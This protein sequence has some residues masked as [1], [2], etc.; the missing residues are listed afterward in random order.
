MRWGGEEVQFILERSKRGSLQKGDS[1]P[2]A[3]QKS[4]VGEK[5][6]CVKI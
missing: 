3:G 1:S 2:L 6:G 4:E 5:G